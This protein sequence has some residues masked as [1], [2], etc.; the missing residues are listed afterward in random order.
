MAKC[1]RDTGWIKWRR[2]GAM[3]CLPVLAA[4]LVTAQTS[5][6]N[7]L[8]QCAHAAVQAR[9]YKTALELYTRLAERNPKDMEARIWVA[10]LESWQKHYTIAERGYREVLAADPGNVEAELGLIDVLSWQKQYPEAQQRLEKLRGRRPRDPE[11]VVRLARLARWQGHTADAKRYYAETLALNPAEPD[12]RREAEATP[13][14]V[15]ETHFRLAFGYSRDDYDFTEAANEGFVELAYTAGRATV[16]GRTHYQ[17]KFG[18]Q[19]PRYAVGTAVK[20]AS[21]T[22]L[23]SEFGWAS[24]NAVVVPRH[25]ALLELTQGLRAGFAMGGGYRYLN[26]RDGEVQVV[27]ASTDIDLHPSLHLYLRYTPALTRFKATG[28]CTWNH[29]GW[30]RLVW[31]AN[32]ALSPYLLYALGSES[33]EAMTVDQLGRFAAHSYGGGAEIRANSRQGFRAGYFYQRRTQGHRQHS[34]NVSYFVNF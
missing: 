10:R 30:T 16:L 20:L 7:E 25:D 18:E 6:E 8:S 1:G 14:T 5:A 15:A 26:F 34:L 29:N 27:S 28:A 33:F 11:V 3:A 17:S 4:C 2:L 32:K 24:A 9:Q 21:R 22:W 31:D 19:R 23:R 12:T 13:T